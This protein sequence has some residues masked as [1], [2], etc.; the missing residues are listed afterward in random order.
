M[1]VNDDGSV[2]LRIVETPISD[3]DLLR[4]RSSELQRATATRSAGM[5]RMVVNLSGRSAGIAKQ[6]ESGENSVGEENNGKDESGNMAVGE[7]K[8]RIGL[9]MHM[10][11]PAEEAERR[12]VAFVSLKNASVIKGP[13]VQPV[14]ASEGGAVGVAR[15]VRK[16]GL[17]EDRRGHKVDGGERRKA[18]VRA[19]RRRA[20]RK[21]AA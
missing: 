18:E 14:K 17:W 6:E 3:D 2:E 19:K 1:D 21:A 12:R 16:E 4:S 8:G 20:E 5:R 10:Q 9:Q 11:L 15:I 7:S 13:H